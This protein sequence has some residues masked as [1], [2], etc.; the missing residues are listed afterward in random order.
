MKK[1]VIPQNRKLQS[2]QLLCFEDETQKVQFDFSPWQTENGT[3][4]AVEWIKESGQASISSESLLA[5]IATATITTLQPGRSSIR[6]KATTTQSLTIV[7]H[8]IVTCKQI[9]QSEST[10]FRYSY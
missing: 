1:Y 9:Q 6:I 3:L 5:N 8:L 7:T 2:R 4:T 10:Q